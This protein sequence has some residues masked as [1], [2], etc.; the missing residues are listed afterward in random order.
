MYTSILEYATINEDSIILSIPLEAIKE[1]YGE[2]SY[3]VEFAFTIK[4][5]DYHNFEY[6][7]LDSA[8]PE[9]S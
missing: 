8:Y 9:H 5:D 1:Y 6:I 4:G 2:I 7:Y 3:I